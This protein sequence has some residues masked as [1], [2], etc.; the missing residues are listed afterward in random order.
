MSHPPLSIDI[1]IT[2]MTKKVPFES[3]R[4]GLLNMDS[5]FD[6]EQILSNLLKFLPTP[7]ETGKLATY[8]NASPGELLDLSPPDKFCLEV[9]AYEPNPRKQRNL[10]STYYC[11]IPIDDE[12]TKA[13]RTDRKHAIPRYILGALSA[14]SSTNDSCLWCLFVFKACQE[15]QKATACK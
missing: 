14:T 6:D 7:E 5:Y 10:Q 8:T 11:I 15:L 9:C 4:P 13:K 3:I 2:S 1:F 12:D